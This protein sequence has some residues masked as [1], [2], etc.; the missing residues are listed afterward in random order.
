MYAIFVMGIQARGTFLHV[1]VSATSLK[2]GKVGS[3]F[4]MRETQKGYDADE[5]IEK[6]KGLHFQF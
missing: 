1:C 5:I 2:R 6:I 3:H 4:L